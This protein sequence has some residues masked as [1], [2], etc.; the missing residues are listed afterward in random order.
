MSGDLAELPGLGSSLAASVVS[1]GVV[2]LVAWVALRWLAGRM[3]VSEREAGPRIRVVARCA[4]EHRRSVYLIAVGDRGF[5]VGAGEGAMVTLGEIELASGVPHGVW[6]GAR[7]TSRAV[8]AK[9]EPDGAGTGRIQAAPQRPGS[10]AFT[11]VLAAVLR[12]GARIGGPVGP[13]PIAGTPVPIAG[14]PVP[15]AGTPVPNPGTSP[16]PLVEAS[17]GAAR[18]VTLVAGTREPVVG[19]S[20]GHDGMVRG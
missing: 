4:L 5:L 15:V 6:D 13:V 20:A 1:L 8:D 16:A 9:G 3:R 19:A 11:Q 17:D 12:R 7:G 18:A 14:T 10:L 2:C